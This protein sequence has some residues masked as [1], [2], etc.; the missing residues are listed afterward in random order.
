[1]ERAIALKSLSALAQRSRLNILSLL[2]TAGS[3]GLAAG[4]IGERLGLRSANLSR[5]LH[6]LHRAGLVTLRRDGRR[7]ICAIEPQATDVLFAAV[8]T[9]FGHPEAA[10]GTKPRH[11]AS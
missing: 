6:R 5:H 8:S 10:A 3:D 4:F 11:S 9:V 1:M 7:I 2:V